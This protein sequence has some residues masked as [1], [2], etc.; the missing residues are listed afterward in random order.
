MRIDRIPLV[1]SAEP[2]SWES[3]CSRR[4]RPGNDWGLQHLFALTVVSLPY[5]VPLALQGLPNP[6]I[7]T[8]VA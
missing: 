3:T 6:P 1:V 8:A 4:G 5:S 7:P 2:L